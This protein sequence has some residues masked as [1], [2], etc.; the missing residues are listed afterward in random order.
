MP[1][2]DELYTVIALVLY[3]AHCI[4]VNSFGVKKLD[5]TQKSTLCLGVFAIFVIMNK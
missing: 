2:Y 3:N 4:H 1:I 5:C